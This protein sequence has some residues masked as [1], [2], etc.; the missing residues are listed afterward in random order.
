MK[1]V[2]AE[3]YE[4]DG[5]TVIAAATVAGGGGGG[6]GQDATGGEGS[7]AGFGVKAYPTGAY[8]I[9]DG[10]VTWCPGVD[11]NRAIGTVGAVAMAYLLLRA[12]RK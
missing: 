9:R 5:V 10:K 7:G 2:F 11:V 1:R 8:V 6:G 3:P 12:R 4:K